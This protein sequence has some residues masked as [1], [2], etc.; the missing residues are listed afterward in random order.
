MRTSERFDRILDVT[1]VV[2]MLGA[3]VTILWVAIVVTQA[4]RQVAPPSQVASGAAPGPVSVVSGLE[5]STRLPIDGRSVPRLT[6]VEF[7]DFQCPY[8]GAYARQTLVRI[9]HDFVDAGTLTYEFRNFPLEGAHPLAVG[10][11]NALECARSQRSFWE[12]HDRLFTFQQ[13]LTPSDLVKHADSIGINRESFRA[14]LERGQ[15][16]LIKSDQDDGIRLGVSG[17]PTF[18]LG[19]R[20]DHGRVEL[21]R[22]IQ[23]AQPYEVF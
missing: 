13:Q 21:L 6:L 14:C 15:D 12:M 4:L 2:A 5:V 10:A 22:R 20:R 23:G 17:T 8:C 9:K 11:A 3:T 7:S 18:F 1:A 16:A 19:V